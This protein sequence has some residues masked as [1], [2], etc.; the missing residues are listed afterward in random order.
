[1]HVKI[2]QDRCPGGVAEAQV[3]EVDFALDMIKFERIDLFNA[4]FAI[5]QCKNS[6][7]C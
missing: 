6:L 4:V 7:R 2:G 5:D 1:M 3:V